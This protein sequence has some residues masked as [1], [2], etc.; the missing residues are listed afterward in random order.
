M[1]FL[2]YGLLWKGFA[3]SLLFVILIGLMGCTQQA[4]VS[5]SESEVSKNAGK[6]MPAEIE[7]VHIGLPSKQNMSYIPF[8]VADKKGIYKKYNLDVKFT[9]VQ[10]GVLALRGLQTGDFDL[11]SSLPESVITGVAEGANVKI[12]G[13]LDNQSMYSIYVSKDIQKISDLKG[14]NAAGMVTGNGTNIQ[15]EYWLKKKGFV[16]NKD[17]RIVN[18]GD[19]A[20]RLLALQQGQASVTILSPPT[21]LKADELGLKRYLM[22]DELKTYNHNMISA[23]GNLIKTKPEV[24]YAFMSAHSE[25]VKYVKNETNRDEIISIIMNDMQMSKSNAEKSFDFVLPALADKGKMNI[26]GVEWAIDTVKEAEISDK[27]V[28]I[29]QLIDERFYAE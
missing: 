16:P 7:Q 6:K 9:Y 28:T 22:R 21:D 25:A 18:A 8:L 27:D 15:L 10:G 17:V 20:E 29:D 13:T 23:N 26:E 19:N 24:I 12:I 2:K 3:A 4:D 1:D 5:T 14:N 11:I